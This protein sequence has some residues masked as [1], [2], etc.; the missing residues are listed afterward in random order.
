ME[1]KEKKSINRRGSQDDDGKL[2][3]DDE[4]FGKRKGGRARMGIQLRCEGKKETMLQ[5]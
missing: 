4:R 5:D 1:K 3:V 2:G